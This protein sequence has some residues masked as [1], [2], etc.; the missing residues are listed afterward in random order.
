MGGVGGRVAGWVR[1]CVGVC[2]RVLSFFLSF[3]PSASVLFS[4]REH[5]LNFHI[6]F[7]KSLSSLGKTIADSQAREGGCGATDCK[8]EKD[9]TVLKTNK[10]GTQARRGTDLGR[11]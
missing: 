2:V 4:S 3:R 6:F 9:W 10:E 1:R 11:P 8:E 5:T 7:V